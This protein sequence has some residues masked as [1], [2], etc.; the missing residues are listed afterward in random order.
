MGVSDVEGG[1]AQSPRTSGVPVTPAAP[2]RLGWGCS[3]VGGRWA[4]ACWVWV[5]WPQSKTQNFP[6]PGG[7]LR[8]PGWGR[9]V[10]SNRLTDRHP[11]CSVGPRLRAQMKPAPFPGHQGL[12]KAAP[13]ARGARIASEGIPVAAGPPWSLMPRQDPLRARSCLPPPP[14]RGQKRPPPHL[15][16]PRPPRPTTMLLLAPRRRTTARP[17]RRKSRS[18]PSTCTRP[19]PRRQSRKRSK[20]KVIALVA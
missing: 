15:R 8:S 12:T 18:G 4:N 20:Q 11:W 1:A 5:C 3:S 2:I 10:Q 14:V 7:P 19:R 13:L 9:W 17:T 6:S 16:P